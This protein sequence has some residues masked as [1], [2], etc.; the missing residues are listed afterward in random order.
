M[1]MQPNKHM[2]TKMK[3]QNRFLNLKINKNE[4]T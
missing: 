3:L 4:Q 1:K 2:K